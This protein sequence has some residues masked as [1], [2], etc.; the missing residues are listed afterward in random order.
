M[1][2]STVRNVC[3]DNMKLYISAQDHA[4]KLK[5]SSYVLLPSVNQIFQYRHN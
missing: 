2:L 4:R 3:V 5:F 1:I